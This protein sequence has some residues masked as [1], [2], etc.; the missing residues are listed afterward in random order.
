MKKQYRTEVLL[1]G[2]AR[3]GVIELVDKYDLDIR[4]ERVVDDR[5]RERESAQSNSRSSP[6]RS[7]SSCLDQ[8]GSTT[9]ST[10]PSP[11]A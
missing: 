8:T 10:T 1:R 3:L 7:S 4:I 9:A 11:Q 2:M 5:L 6:N